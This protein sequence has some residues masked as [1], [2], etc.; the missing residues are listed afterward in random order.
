[1]PLAKYDRVVQ[2]F[3]KDIFAQEWAIV[4]RPTQPSTE[5]NLTRK[6][7]NTTTNLQPICPQTL[8]EDNLWWKTTFDGW[9]L[10]MDDNCWWKTLFGGRTLWWRTTFDKRQLLR[11]DN[12][13]WKTAFDGRYPLME[14][15]LRWKMAFDGR[16][17]L[18]EDSFWW[19]AAFWPLGTVAKIFCLNLNI[20]T[21]SKQ[22]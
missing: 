3:L 2:V 22:C 1:M 6:W 8:I 19:K 12:L 7:L 16:Q 9:W 5:L 11:E 21:K 4:K 18:M 15:G 17:P 20:T 13:W 14:D 10:F